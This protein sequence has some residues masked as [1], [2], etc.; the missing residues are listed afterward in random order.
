[1]L[2]SI[3]HELHP[4]FGR[5]AA[6]SPQKGSGVSSGH[7]LASHVLPVERSVLKWAMLGS[8]QRPLPCEGRSI[9]SCL[10]AGVQKYLQIEG[11]H[12][13]ILRVR[14]PLF[15][16][17]GVLLVYMSLTATPTP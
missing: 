14:L 1:M 16:W 9:T 6:R 4:Y 15:V 3:P 5:V 13:G 10:F 12:S 7:S 11:F 8:N 2:P 17:V